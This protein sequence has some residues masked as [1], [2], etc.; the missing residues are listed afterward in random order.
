MAER[1]SYQEGTPNWI[2]LS[3]PEVDASKR[4]YGQLFGW[5]LED[6]HDPV[7]DLV[8]V[9]ARKDGKQ[10]A[11]IGPQQPGMQGMPA[12]WLTYIA[13]DDADAAV[14]R[15]KQAG[16]S[17]MAEPMDVMGEG[18]MA[19]ATDP[20]GATFAVWQA[21]KHYGA[22]LVNEHATFTWNELLT[23]DTAAARDFYVSAFGYEAAEQPMGEGA[24]PYV[25][26]QLDAETPV[27]GMMNMRGFPEQVPP[28]WNVYFNVDDVDAFVAKAK[29][30]G[31]NVLIDPPVDTPFGRMSQIHDPQHGAFSVMTPP[32]G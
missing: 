29:E 19:V 10:V 12:M 22:Q 27:G 13:V 16:G 11:G 26:W 18:R 31:G 21:G 9:I 14:D 2:D 6:I 7:G 15:I 8:Y 3:T 5:E 4:F 25:L 23:R 30:L 32:T 28:H 1:T 17:V 20:T 24:E